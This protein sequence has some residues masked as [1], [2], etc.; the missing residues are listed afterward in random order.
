LKRDAS[1]IVFA[2]L[3]I[4]AIRVAAP[5]D[6]ATG[7][8]P[9]QVAYINDIVTNGNWLVQH[10]PDGSAAAK[11]PLY[12]WLAAAPVAVTGVTSEP[13]LKLPSLLA[14][15]LALLCVWN[16]ATR[17]VGAGAAFGASLLLATAG[18]F[19]KHVYFAR[20]DMLLTLLIVAQ[21]WGAVRGRPIVLWFAAALAMMTKGP[22]GIVLPAI[23]LSG[24]WWHRGELRP[25][26]REMRPAIGLPLALLPFAI[27]FAAAVLTEGRAVWDQMVV[28]ETVDRFVAGSKSKEHRHVLYYV[29]HLVA[30]MLPA[31]LLALA[32][33]RH[34]RK[35]ELALPLFWVAGMLVFLSLIPS[36]RAD[37]LFPILPA[38]CMLAG[39]TLRERRGVAIALSVV[40]MIGTAI[41]QF[42]RVWF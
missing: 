12:N 23:A 33:L 40:M 24:W 14:G 9:L 13:L 30:R 8:Q 22:I 17:L 20:T 35:P 25:R 18:M 21:I 39:Y 2:Y 15:L 5:S 1:L 4:V 26:W 41:Y 32:A 11:P 37:R 3:V 42:N 19:S 16:L 6:L 28:A 7:D 31:S 27:W 36:K 38:M 34:R 29:P 10:L